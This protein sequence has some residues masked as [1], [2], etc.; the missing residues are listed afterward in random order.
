M[1]DGVD[2]KGPAVT[3]QMEQ[4][5]ASLNSPKAP[6]DGPDGLVPYDP[7]NQSPEQ[8]VEGPLTSQKTSTACTEFWCHGATIFRLFYQ[9]AIIAGIVLIVLGAVEPSNFQVL[10]WVGVGVLPTCYLIYLVDTFCFNRNLKY[11]SNVGL[12]N[13]IQNHIAEVKQ[14]VPVICWHMTC[15]HNETRYRRVS[16]QSNGK[17]CYRTESHTVRCN[18]WSGSQPFLFSSCWDASPPDMSGLGQYKQTRIKF[19]KTFAFEDPNTEMSFIAQ[20][21]G[22]VAAN[23]WRDIHYDF[24]EEFTVPGFQTAVVASTTT[25]RPFYLKKRYYFL[26]VL[27]L[28]ELPYS[29]CL[30]KGCPVSRFTYKKIIRC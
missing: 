25:E 11:L 2:G 20:R 3:I 30:K 10:L 12:I 1:N 15:Y 27:F 21:D 13:G 14:A 4:P 9:G 5:I 18:T 28:M 24:T 17:T 7:L 6:L 26:A 29:F 19:Y 23:R 16:Y 8:L 22:F